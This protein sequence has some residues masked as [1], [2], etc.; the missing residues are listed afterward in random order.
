MRRA[1]TSLRFLSAMLAAGQ[2]ACATPY[3]HRGFRGG[4]SDFEAQPGVHY[5]A[6]E[7]NGFTS[8]ATVA[9]YW[10]QRAA[11]I[12]GGRD[13]YQVLSQQAASELFVTGSGGNVQSG[14][15]PSMEGYITCAI[16]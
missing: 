15:K 12:C 10:H 9:E 1:S 7:G 16:P 11:E 13:R 2:L 5:V 3:Q 14:R 8:R 4:Y 6:F